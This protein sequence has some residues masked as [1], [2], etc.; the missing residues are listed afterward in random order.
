M[1]DGPLGNWYQSLEK[2]PWTPP[3]WVFGAAWTTIM[4][5]FSVYMSRLIQVNKSRNVILV[6]SIQVVLNIAWNFLFLVN[7]EFKIN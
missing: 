4:I 5:C 3:G 7:F 2:A 6:F 1:S